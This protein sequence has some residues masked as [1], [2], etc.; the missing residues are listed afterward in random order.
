MRGLFAQELLTMTNFYGGKIMELKIGKVKV[1]VIQGDISTQDVDAIGLAANDRLWMGGR[2]A[3]ALKRKAGEDI[4]TEAMKQGPLNI[5]E[6]AVTSGGELT[7]KKILHTVVMG[8]DL[9]PTTDTIRHG[10]KN[11]L[12]KADELKLDSL[13]IPAFG[14]GMAKVP[15]QESARAMVEQI[16]DVLLGTNNLNELR[17]FFHNEGIFKAFVEEFSKKFSR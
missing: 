13:A 14:T 15:A 3:D 8:Q 10:T 6:V 2:V 16:I 5:G 11:L 1:L 4:E 17:F 7:R 12:L 9:A